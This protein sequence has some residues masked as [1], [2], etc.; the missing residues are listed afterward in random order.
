MS[1]RAGRQQKI[2]RIQA[3]EMRCY[4][5]LLNIYYNDRVSNDE[6]RSSIQDAISPNELCLELTTGI[7]VD[8]LATIE[9]KYIGS[10]ISFIQTKY[11]LKSI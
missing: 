2:E 6:V 9:I 8:P 1:V 11:I 4:R 3:L 5:R 10:N 7:H